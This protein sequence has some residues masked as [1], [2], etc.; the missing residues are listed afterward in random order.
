ME[1][2]S[3]YGVCICRAGYRYDS[4][5]SSCIEIEVPNQENGGNSSSV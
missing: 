4:T 3:D 2:S 5:T 1:P